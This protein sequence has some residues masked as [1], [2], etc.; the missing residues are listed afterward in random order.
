[1]QR[2]QR[3]QRMKFINYLI[4]DASKNC[5][6]RATYYWFFLQEKTLRPLPL[7]VELYVHT[8]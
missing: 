5:T 6:I 3:M 1:M 7:C 8:G 2:M 4:T